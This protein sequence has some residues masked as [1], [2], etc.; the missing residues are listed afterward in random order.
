MRQRCED[1]LAKINQGSVL[2]SLESF[3]DVFSKLD[4]LN[5][6]PYGI[7][8]NDPAQVENPADLQYLADED[9]LT[10]IER[11]RTEMME[12]LRLNDV[13]VEM[14]PSMPQD[15]AQAL[16]RV[17]GGK[18]MSHKRLLMEFDGFTEEQA[19][20]EIQRIMDEEREV[21]AGANAPLGDSSLILNPRGGLQQGLLDF[22]QT[23]H[24]HEVLLDAEGNGVSDRS[25]VDGHNHNVLNGQP[26][27]EMGHTHPLV[28]QQEQGTQPEPQMAGAGMQP[29]NQN[30]GMAGMS[31]GAPTQTNLQSTAIAA[32][33]APQATGGFR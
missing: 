15:M 24:Q 2:I 8:I 12:Y 17:G 23:D 11:K 4:V 7:F 32:G 3:E 9:L 22:G 30:A 19:E 21:M 16:E 18:S 5:D 13:Q 1:A 29:S 31:P 27:M 26:L 28:F 20:E 33:T 10:A 6:N 14:I 25:P